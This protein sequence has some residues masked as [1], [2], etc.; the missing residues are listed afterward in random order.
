VAGQDCPLVL[1][2][3]TQ[4]PLSFRSLL[5]ASPAALDEDDEV[6]RQQRSEGF[7]DRSCVD[8]VPPRDEQ[9]D[10]PMHRAIVEQQHIAGRWGPE[11][12]SSVT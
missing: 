4:W 6:L 7:L 8:T 12:H 3:A 5:T 9:V 1:G 11:K 2:R 10:G